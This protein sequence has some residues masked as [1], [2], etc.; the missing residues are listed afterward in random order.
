MDWGVQHGAESRLSKPLK[1]RFLRVLEPRWAKIAPRARQEPPK[2]PPR[3][4]QE[5]PRTLQEGL[6]DRFFVDVCE[7]LMIC[8]VNVLWTCY[9]SQQGGGDGRRQLD[10]APPK[11]CSCVRSTPVLS[12]FPIL[13]CPPGIY[14]RC[15]DQGFLVMLAPC[16]LQVGLF[17]LSCPTLCHQN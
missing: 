8:L 5:P 6:G 14:A 9:L 1:N 7:F 3:A 10:P 2:S 16:W 12:K 4:S 15:R 13:Q 11:G 17:D